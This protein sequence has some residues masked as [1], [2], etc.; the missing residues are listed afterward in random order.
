MNGLAFYRDDNFVA[1]RVS[2][3]FQ[4]EGDIIVRG[5]ASTGARRDWMKSNTADV[6]LMDVR[7]PDTDGI[8]ATAAISKLN[9]W[10]AC[11]F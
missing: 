11:S 2:Q 6:V 1:R 5:E 7:L 3:L 10:P 9:R 4:A 8:E